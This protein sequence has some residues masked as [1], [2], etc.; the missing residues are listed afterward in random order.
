MNEEGI[1]S[2]RLAADT[3]AASFGLSNSRG[4]V[5]PSRGRFSAIEGLRM[6]IKRY[7]YLATFVCVGGCSTTLAGICDLPGDRERVKERERER[8][9]E[10]E[11]S[12]FGDVDITALKR[13]FFPVILS[14]L[15]ST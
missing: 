7:R 3:A 15:S 13:I 1:S 12:S 10:A 9:R 11:K 5:L 6:Y 14:I 8:E 4:A 2:W